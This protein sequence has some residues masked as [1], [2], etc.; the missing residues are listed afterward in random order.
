MRILFIGGSRMTGPFAVRDLVAAG[1]EI[2]LLHRSRSESPL[3]AGAT[4]IQGDKAD[5]LSLRQYLASLRLDVVVHMIAFTEADANTFIETVAGVVP[6]AVVVS[7]ID[8]YRAFG[9]IH[10]TEPGPPDPTPLGEEAPLR[11]K[12]SIHGAAAE[13]IAVERIVRSHPKLSCTILRYPAVYGPGDHLHRLRGWVRRMDDGRPFI[14]MG[15]SQAGWRFTHGYV[16]NV[17]AALALA[18]TKPQAADRIYNVG[19]AVT[20]TW[21]QWAEMIGSAAGWKGGV[22]IVPDDCLPRHLADNLDFRQ[23]WAIDSSRIRRELGYA[24]AVPASQCL[25]R[26]IAWERADRG[27]DDSKEFDYAA[28]D[29]ASGDHR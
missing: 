18:I 23:G 28:E 20:P 9:R 22:R 19:D 11:E 12:P 2:W 4:Q 5:L 29:A 15:Q 3:L 6:R 26:A 16:E 7:S 14:L 17:A 10:R 21:A 13:K 27:P 25:Q 1:H 8:V 24:E